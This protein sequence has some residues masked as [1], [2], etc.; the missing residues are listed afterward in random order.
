[1]TAPTAMHFWRSPDE[2]A[3]SET[4]RRFLD[5]EFPEQ[6]HAFL[7]PMRRR[8]VLRLM[9]ASLALAGL[10]ACTRLPDEEI[11]PYVRA[12]EDFVPGQP[13]YFAT[14]MSMGGFA[15]GVLVESHLG[16]PTKVEG[17]P[18]HPAS[19]GATD[20]F[21]QAS[22]L[23]LYDPDRS[24]VVNRGGRI[25]TWA[26]FV[27]A[28]NRARDEQR[29]KKGAGL[30]IVSERITSPTLADQIAGLLLQFPLAR[31][32]QYEAVTRDNVREGARLAFGDVVHTRYRVDQADVIVSLDA[33]FLGSGPSNLRDAR[34][35]ADRRRPAPGQR[36]NRLYVIE[37]TPTITGTMAD[38]RLRMPAIDV[39]SAARRLAR[40]VDQG[41][42]APGAQRDAADPFLEATAHDLLEHRGSSL[43][44]AGDAQ[45]PVVHA[46]AHA[47]NDVLGNNGRTVEQ[48]DP[49]EASPVDD[50]KSL[51]ELV[52]DM[53]R[54]QV[55]LLLILG[56]NP[57]FTA[58]G[59]VPF[60]E[61]LSHV[62][63]RVHL[64]LYED[65]TSALCDWH[66][67]EA[68]YLEAWGDGRAF[69]GTVSV[70]Q[71]LI[72][73]F[74]GGK[75]AHELLA[76]FAGDVDR[77]GHD[78]IQDY[79]RRHTPVESFDERWQRALSNGVLAETALPAR[80]VSLKTPV[81]A[82]LNQTAPERP[83][84]L[85]L[86][87]H[88]DPTIWDG[89]F[90]NNA[91][92]QE[93]PK[94]L[95]KLTWDAAA[96]IS[97]ATGKRLAVA[98]G[99][100]VD[101]KYRGGTLRA[102]VWILPG[103]ADESIAVTLGYGRTRGGR[104]AAGVGF[105]A[106]AARASDAPWFGAPVEIRKTGI[107]YDLA[108]TQNHFSMEGRDLVRVGNL[109]RF[110]RD[111]R[112]AESSDE[113]RPD[114]TLYP[115]FEYPSHAWAMS[116][117]LNACIGCGVCTIACQAENN[118]PVVGKVEVGRGREMHWIRVDR[119]FEG[120]ADSPAFYHQPVPC[121]HCE[122]APCELVCP[123]GATVH[124]D[125]GLNQMVYNRCVGTRYCSNNC[126]YKVRRFNFFQYS[127]WNTPSLKGL[128]NPDVTVRSRGVME[129][130]TYCVQR[131][132]A[133]KI[134][135]EKQDRAL[136]DGEIVTACQAACPTRAIVFGDLNDRQS[137]AARLRA[138]PRNYGLLTELNTRPRTTYLARLR[139]PNAQLDTT[140]GH[141]T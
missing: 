39:E 62:R 133:A 108:S 139:N 94:P 55:D 63:F 128:R 60:A 113:P 64:G 83:A 10:S 124:S 13:L 106:N 79:W 103:Q 93:L 85:E 141:G 42:A 47:M 111:P 118:I 77:T 102:P 73:P 5:A 16:R 54:G 3:G 28:L 127:D 131:I 75:S 34:H 98:N 12:P 46:L 23:T 81:A 86:T 18:G 105:N 21:A 109:D 122:N 9:G 57:A 116:I 43:V 36:M 114:E 41:S 22:V 140:S 99:D 100:V 44:I 53:G 27:D 78:I 87:F 121:M 56:G 95:T 65:E 117:D 51:A 31:W 126:P 92:L 6:A 115:K 136:R 90:A 107:H 32:H 76:T 61:Q 138:D 8:D 45:P 35:F 120:N 74:Y 130:C 110:A 33:D 72:A 14:A 67:P 89:R 29:L 4:F 1:M 134:D 66:V 26:A 11:V 69:D 104:V 2:L 96:L 97:P 68:H 125:E 48:T 123:V 7:D 88:P 71:P 50:M 38:H 30:R 70:V 17:N 132:N 58:P 129:K 19:L 137:Q 135:A 49:V 20:I 59:D 82:L 40:L 24:Q 119:Y 84:G 52:A 112:F 80:S 15:K 37:S 25:S 101:L 91:W